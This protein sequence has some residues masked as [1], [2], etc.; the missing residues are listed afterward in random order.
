MSISELTVKESLVMMGAAVVVAYMIIAG[1]TGQ[2]INVNVI[3]E[4]IN[5]TGI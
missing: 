4:F 2:G 3:L 5:S 1:V